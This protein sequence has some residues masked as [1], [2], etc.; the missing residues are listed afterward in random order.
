MLLMMYVENALDRAEHPMGCARYP[1]S[2]T[3]KFSAQTLDCDMRDRWLVALPVG[4]TLSK[5]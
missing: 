3:P 1:L 2:A 5:N 4:R